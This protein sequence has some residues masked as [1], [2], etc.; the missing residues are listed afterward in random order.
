MHRT[1]DVVFAAALGVLAAS[2][3]APSRAG[4]QEQPL[5][6]VG[7]KLSGSQLNWEL[8]DVD[9]DPRDGY[10]LY[11]RKSGSGYTA[12]R[13]EALL[14]DD[15]FLHG[16]PVEQL[17]HDVVEVAL[18]TDVVDAEHVGVVDARGNPRFPL[19]A[20]HDDRGGSRL[21]RQHLQC[22]GRIEGR[23]VSPVDVGG[24]PLPEECLDP[25]PADDGAQ[26]GVTL[27]AGRGIARARRGRGRSA[28]AAAGHRGRIL[29]RLAC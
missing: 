6:N 22:D 27:V 28:V 10:R 8:R 1:A 15:D 7:A 12:Y 2:V 29:A 24:A 19:E 21:G 18:A 14:T 17:H 13:L 23:V 9:D 16:L 3:I 25:A 11:E 26:E 5:P 20:L 4:A